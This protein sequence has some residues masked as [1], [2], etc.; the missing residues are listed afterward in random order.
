MWRT[1][2]EFKSWFD[3]L[4][5][6]KAGVHCANSTV[7]ASASIAS[8]A[9]STPFISATAEDLAAATPE[10]LEP[11]ASLSATP[12]E[13]IASLSATPLETIASLSAT[14]LETIASYSSLLVSSATPV[15][16]GG[17]SVP[18]PSSHG[19]GHG[20]KIAVIVAAVLLALVLAYLF[21]AVEIRFCKFVGNVFRLLLNRGFQGDHESG[22]HSENFDIHDNIEREDAR[23]G[24]S[25]GAKFYVLFYMFLYDE[26]FDNARLRYVQRKFAANGIGPDGQPLDP[27]FVGHH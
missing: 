3:E 5:C 7:A 15:P 19:R 22:L 1:Y 17:S 18:S 24:L 21:L 11:I 4:L 2:G 8:S 12:L 20:F 10:T 27:K 6:D 14:P 23:H 13:T 9:V 25:K 16:D 26:S